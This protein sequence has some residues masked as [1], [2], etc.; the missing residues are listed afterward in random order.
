MNKIDT[1]IDAY[2]S[3]LNLNAKVTIIVK[4]LAHNWV[5]YYSKIKP[6]ISVEEDNDELFLIKSQ[7][8]CYSIED[9]FLNKLMRNVL[10]FQYD[11]SSANTFFATKGEF[12]PSEHCLKI[13][14]N[15]IDDSVNTV[16]ETITQ[17]TGQKPAE[18]LHDCIYK[19]VSK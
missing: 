8:G 19:T 15:L 6:I 11:Y 12:E 18:N 7:N 4:E 16:I 2:A 1:F 17:I 10:Y 14:E 5:K 9:Y 13:N 3:V